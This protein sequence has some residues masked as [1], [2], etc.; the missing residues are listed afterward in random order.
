MKANEKRKVE[1]GTKVIILS[2]ILIVF[3]IALILTLQKGEI[4]SITY[5]TVVLKEK[6][7]EKEKE[8]R[9]LYASLLL[10]DESAS[11]YSLD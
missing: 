10:K 1:S 2:I 6:N 8:K 4:R 7:A 3:A 11:T 9:A 5:E